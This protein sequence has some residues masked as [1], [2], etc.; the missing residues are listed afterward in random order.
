MAWNTEIEEPTKYMSFASW[1]GYYG[2]NL[3]NLSDREKDRRRTEYQT[4]LSGITT[5][6]TTTTPTTTPTTT[7]PTTTTPVVAAPAVAAPALPSLGDINVPA[8]AV[9]PAPPY[10][11]SPAQT[12]FEEMVGGKITDWVEAGG[13]GIPEETQAQ[14]IQQQTDVI[15]AGEA[16]SLRVMKN[17]MERRGITNS[18]FIFAGEQAIR[19][20]TSKT[21]AAG[22]ADI[23]IKSALMKL[24]S[25]EVAMG[26]AA[27]FLGYLGEM[28]A[29]K[30]QPVFQTWAAQQQANLYQYQAK[31][32]I[33][34]TQ[35]Q[36]AYQQQNLILAG[37]IAAEAAEQQHIWDVEITEMEI[38]AANQQAAAEGAGKVFGTTLGWIFGKI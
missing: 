17:N 5:T 23:Q 19:S 37:N 8:P 31:M 25:F 34:K 4:W 1:I 3:H 13:Y 10:E 26:Q 33:Y 21:I 27:Q 20:N 12:A 14:M 28:S 35:L 9:T 38:E 16:E 15:K 22:I 11:I 29:L 30:Y 6:P 36:Q 2:A 7:T 32:D 18:G 24:A